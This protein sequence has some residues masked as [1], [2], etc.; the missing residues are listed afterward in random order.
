MGLP[1]RTE[2]RNYRRVA[3]NRADEAAAL[4]RGD[5]Y[6]AS[7]YLSG[8]SIECILKAL[9][10]SAVPPQEYREVLASFRGTQGHDLAWLKQRYVSLTGAQIP[11]NVLKAMLLTST[12]SSE[13]RYEPG[14]VHPRDAEQFLAAAQAILAWADSRI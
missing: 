4:L 6:T 13:L 5:Y 12:W 8:Y 7:V 14:N 11:K 9:I 1:R 10:L 3:L 2:A